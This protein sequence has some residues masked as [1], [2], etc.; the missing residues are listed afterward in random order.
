MITLTITELRRRFSAV[1]KRVNGGES[2]AITR[3]GKLVAFLEP[4][5]P[6][7]S[8]KEIFAGMEEI[9][10]RS[11]LPKGVTIKSMIEDGR[12]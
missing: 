6:G 11:R 12:T 10:K 1:V 4:P 5:Q 2:I 9:Q 8:L 7:H 3:R